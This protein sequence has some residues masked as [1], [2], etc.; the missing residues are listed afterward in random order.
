MNFSGSRF[1]FSIW[2]RIGFS[3]LPV[4]PET[5]FSIC[6][7]HNRRLTKMPVHQS[8]HRRREFIWQ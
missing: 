2:R 3:P 6:N 7:L 1:F 4:M 5:L 8:S